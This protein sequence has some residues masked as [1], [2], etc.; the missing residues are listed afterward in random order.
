VQ[1][2]SALAFG[3]LSDRI[4]Q[5]GAEEGQ[6]RRWLMIGAH[7]VIGFS[8]L[9]AGYATTNEALVASLF[10]A[11]LA[12]GIV[13]TNIYAVAQIFAGR[14]ASGSWVGIQNALGNA[15]GIFGPII[16]GMLIDATGNYVIAFTLAA[17][18]GGLGAVIWLTALRNVA[19]LDLDAGSDRPLKTAA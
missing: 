9:A 19:E 8:I 7:V 3:W 13:S 1:G 15:S 18:V 11:A 2:V 4:V 14:R 17:A 12:L 16:T 6:V 10:P 5:R